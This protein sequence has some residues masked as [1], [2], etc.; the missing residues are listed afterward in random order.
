[1]NASEL[2]GE[3]ARGA[4]RL[5]GPLSAEARDLV[6]ES[7]EP[8]SFAFG[9]TIVREGE[10]PD[11]VYM[12]AT[13]SARV[14]KNG[15]HGDEVALRSLGPG[16][17]F[18]ALAVLDHAPRHAS[19]RASDEVVAWR[20]ERQLFL[21]LLH[22]HPEIRSSFE[23]LAHRRATEDFLLLYSS[24][25][26]LPP[27][28]LERLADALERVEVSAGDVVLS[29][30]GPPGP[31]YVIEHGH[32]RAF[33]RSRGGEE[34]LEYLRTG[35]FF[36]ELALHRSEP[37]AASVAAVSDGGLLRL[38]RE[39]FDALSAEYPAFRSRIEDRVAHHDFHHLARVPLDFA[40]EILPAA[41][42]HEH[43][44]EQQ[45]E[46]FTDRT[47]GAAAEFD[48]VAP[49][50]AAATAPK[51]PRRFPHVYQLDEADCGAA[52]L[53]MV[54]RYFGKKVALSRIRE[55]VHTSTDGTSLA[56]ITAG[57]AELGLAARAVR[58]SK[59]RLDEL[60]LPAIVHWEGNHWVVLHEVDHDRVRYAD[61]ESGLQHVPRAEFLER[62]SGYAALV[63]Y[64]EKFEDVAEARHSL[65]WLWGFFRPHRRTLVIAVLLALVAAGLQLLLPIMTQV[66]IDDVFPDNDVGLL[67][68]ILAALVGVL[69][70]ITGATLVQ[71]YLLARVSVR[72]DTDALDFLTGRLLDLPMTY[73]STR[74][75]GD[76]ERRLAGLRQ[77]REFFVGSGVQ[78]LTAAT[79]VLAAVVLMFVYSWVL[80]LVFLATVPLYASLLRFSS[81]RLQPMYE[82]LEE[83]YGKYAAYQIDAIRGIET[84]KAMSAEETLRASM[85]A[86]FRTLASRLFRTQFLVLSYQ[87]GV[88]LLGFVS[89]AAFLVVGSAQVIHGTL[90][91][92]E[93]VAFNSLVALA[94]G[95]V[96]VLLLLWDELQIAKI[97]IARLD[98]VIDQEPEQGADR[99][100]LLP[101]D[102]LAGE[103]ELA[104]VGF[105][106]GSSQ[107]PPILDAISLHVEPG[108]TIA[109]VGRSGSGKTTLVKLLAGLME[110]T[111]G[112]IRYDGVDL[113]SIDY[114]ALRRR[115]GVVLQESY[116]F[117]GTIAENI[118]LGDE[119]PDTDRVTW[120]ARAA[121]AHDFVDRLPLGYDTRVGESGLR[122][123]GGQ[124]QRIAIAR[125]LYH[126]PP[127]LLFDEA[128]SA[129]DSESERAVK[130]SMDELFEGRT[131]FVIAHRLS[132]IRD[133]DRILVLD[134]GRL[135]EDGTHDELLARQGLYYYLASQQLGL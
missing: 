53:A 29:E 42:A 36:G 108:Q 18:G 125:A 61:P 112:S 106:Y 89:L 113:S 74:R 56:G 52:C 19:V 57:A 127:V 47:A 119:H 21:A 31:M 96:L 3:A 135:V 39:D 22:S 105:H 24:F 84:V 79:Q 110:P 55:V 80:A 65:A 1:V 8:L 69:I 26:T 78:A 40:Q 101:V 129:L 60:P 11:G 94:N 102:T 121:S 91:V 95:P 71:R 117:E 64:T 93:F 67:W 28:A 68:I 5:L 23:A 15:V 85:L 70:A 128:T 25:A 103:I 13:G 81:R 115:V 48:G 43:V 76:I 86:Q 97:L 20:L 9:A 16:D 34:D 35:D 90:T 100:G 131:S 87:G 114:R 134:R 7:F 123:S 49:A 73:F 58:A 62:W 10:E 51:P 14:V 12:L 37:Q 124:K 30:G 98:D 2:T 120:A 118:A 17:W 75:T 116:L 99:S 111:S 38:R 41:A 66:V 46:P 72:V 104:D 83:A 27:D 50:A 133:A 92:G 32:F 6:G 122:L 107:A 88:Q 130:E 126:R 59:S 33:H 63:S 132:T 54:C 45:A 82:S 4:E 44:S 77:V 109:I